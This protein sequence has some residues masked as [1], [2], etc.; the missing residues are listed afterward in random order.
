M[1]LLGKSFRS[2]IEDL[3]LEAKA[4]LNEFAG[5]VADLWIDDTRQQAALV[6]AQAPRSS[7]EARATSGAGGQIVVTRGWTDFTGSKEAAQRRFRNATSLH[8][9]LV[10]SA[11]REYDLLR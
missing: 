1:P 2:V 7:W 5:L 3:E 9:R 6:K 8:D 4:N 11:A 10:S